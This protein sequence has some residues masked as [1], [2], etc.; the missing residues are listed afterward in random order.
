MDDESPQEVGRK[1]EEVLG[2]LRA[3][4][5]GGADQLLSVK[6]VAQRL[7]ASTQYV[8]GLIR[9][10]D[11]TAVDINRNPNRPLLRVRESELAAYIDRLINGK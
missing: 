6:H 5:A 10:G 7:D 4:L 8:R 3:S 2:L 11:L 1:I 9:A